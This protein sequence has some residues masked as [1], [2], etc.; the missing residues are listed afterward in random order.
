MAEGDVEI[1]M[2]DQTGDLKIEI[3]DSGKPDYHKAMTDAEELGGK[4]LEGVSRSFFLTLK[5][6]PQGLRE[7]LSLAYLLARAAD[8]MADTA[9]VPGELRMDCLREFDRLLQAETRDAAGEA[10]L[11]ARLKE[12]FVPLQEDVNEARLL[13]RLPEAF[14]AFRRSPQRQMTA[15]RG[16]LTPIIRGQLLDIERFPVDGQVRS[17][18]SA[19]E[20]DDYTYLVAGCVGEFWTRLC[21]T[22]EEGIFVPSV[23][24]EQMVERGIRYGKGLQ[25]IN[26]LR[27]VGKDLRMGR[28]YFPAS[29]LAT[30]G[31]TAAEAVADPAKLAPVAA[32]WISLCREHLEAGLL[33][34]DALQHKRLLFATAL[35]LL[36]GIRTLALIENASPGD[37]AAGIKVSRAEI[38]KILFDAGIASL[39]KGGIRKLAEK[40]KAAK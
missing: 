32:P 5:A 18:R 14:E 27:D 22:E 2:A 7:P 29:E 25:L 39:R 36:I 17:L 6:L 31:L 19:K 26:I 1:E 38:G 20:L 3:L 10:L 8:T 28:C 37:L 12:T 40:L 35:P 33:Y 24:L 16:V 21:A 4:L 34:L 23:T 13:E 15:M 11:C 30:H 9:S